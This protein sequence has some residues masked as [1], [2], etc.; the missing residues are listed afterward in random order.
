[1]SKSKSN[2]AV[3]PVSKVDF[4]NRQKLSK[5]EASNLI[6]KAQAGGNDARKILFDHY[7]YLISRL[8]GRLD[9]PSTLLKKLCFAGNEA[10]HLAID[11]YKTNDPEHFT[12]YAH[13]WIRRRVYSNFQRLTQPANL[14][15]TRLGAA[16]HRVGS[17]TDGIHTLGNPLKSLLSSREYEVIQHRF[18]LDGNNRKT[19]AQIAAL[20][21][22]N[23]QWVGKLERQALT[24]IIN[25]SIK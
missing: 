10:L 16:Q 25:S 14:K 18:G 12:A 19:L 1:V 11:E 15:Q 3:T 13:R 17:Q 8:I 6:A 5:A 20:M 21:K 4:R 23:R 24:K 9:A 7:S 22:K 2:N